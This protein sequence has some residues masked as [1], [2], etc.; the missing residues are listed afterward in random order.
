M[1]DRES[2]H[3]WG[4]IGEREKKNKRKKQ[5][6]EECANLGGGGGARDTKFFW[7]LW[8]C[9]LL[10]VTMPGLFISLNSNCGKT[11]YQTTFT[12]KYKQMQR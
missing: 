2:E 4:G 8:S 5:K 12:S 7:C 6:M 9:S 11:A 1:G 10:L 3:Y